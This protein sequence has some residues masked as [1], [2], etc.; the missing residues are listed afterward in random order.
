[1]TTGSVFRRFGVVS[2]F[3]RLVSVTAFHEM[4]P[5]LAYHI[6]IGDG[7]HLIPLLLPDGDSRDNDLGSRFCERHIV[8]L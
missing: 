2:P 3:V 6:G 5:K 4:G 7:R 8:L 1:M